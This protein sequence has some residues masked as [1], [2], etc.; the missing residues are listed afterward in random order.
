MKRKDIKSF[1]KRKLYLLKI[2]S[3]IL[4][5]YPQHLDS[6][7]NQMKILIQDE[8]CMF[9]IISS[10]AVGLGIRELQSTMLKDYITD[11][12]KRIAA[13]IGQ[14]QMMQYYQKRF[15]AMDL[16]VSQILL[17][18]YDLATHKSYIDIRNTLTELIQFSNHGR[19]AIIPIINE[20]DTTSGDIRFDDNDHLASLI[21]SKMSAHMLILFSDVDGLYSNYSHLRGQMNKGKEQENAVVSEIHEITKDIENLAKPGSKNKFGRGGMRSKLINAKIATSSGVK[22][23]IANACKKDILL[24]IIKNQKSLTDIDRSK[25]NQSVSLNHDNIKKNT[26]TNVQYPPYKASHMTQLMIFETLKLKE[27]W[28][29]FG[30]LPKGSIFIDKGAEEAILKNDKS[31][32]SSGIKKIQGV[33]QA[34]DIVCIVSIENSEEIGRGMISISSEELRHT[35]STIEVINRDRL[36]HFKKR[37]AFWKLHHTTRIRKVINPGLLFDFKKRID[38]KQRVKQTRASAVYSKTIK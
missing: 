33:F 1:H 22:V 6:L 4:L 9:L 16:S 25:K 34:K 14:M 7:I 21:A 10:G 3:K 12:Q 13:S 28:I 29:L 30:A 18:R 31:L 19:Q 15:Q 26:D 32:L 24:F 11:G 37:R 5:E 38:K 27:R 35:K 8:N 36:S 23:L 2:G 20:N 17:S